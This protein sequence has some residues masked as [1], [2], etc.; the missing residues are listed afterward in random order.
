MH[1]KFTDKQ[2]QCFCQN[3]G[4]LIEISVYY[5][6]GPDL[7]NAFLETAFELLQLLE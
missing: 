3:G 1:A 6:P 7:C 4:K 2:G 5:L